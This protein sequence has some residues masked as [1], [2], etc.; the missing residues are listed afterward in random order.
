MNA[1]LLI[2]F[3]A[4]TFV[5][6]VLGASGLYVLVYLYRWEWNRAIVAGIFFLSALVVVGTLVVLRALKRIEARLDRVEAA[7]D[8]VTSVLGEENDQHANRHFDWLRRPP[9]RLGVFVP[10]LLGAG[11]LLSFVAFVLER[12]AGAVGGPVLDRR[13][14]RLVEPDLPLGGDA[15]GSSLPER[16]RRRAMIAGIAIIAFL[17]AGSWIAVDA[18]GDATQ[19]R[20]EVPAFAGTTEI[21]MWIDQRGEPRPPDEVAMTLWTACQTIAPAEVAVVRIDDLDGDRA[22]VVL[23]HQLG[24]LHR[25]RLEG[26]LTDLKADLVVADILRVDMRPPV[27]PT[28]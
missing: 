5:V 24:D 2:R 25:V 11:V 27:E 8:P 7:R 13:T 16:P 10:V 6:V 18:I 22:V 9:D 23:D 1:R 20:P 4:T 3:V 26:C 14:A 28:R 12:V 21:E 17:I 19:S 15:G